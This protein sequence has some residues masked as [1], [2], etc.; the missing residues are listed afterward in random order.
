MPQRRLHLL[1]QN[2]LDQFPYSLSDGAS[3]PSRSEPSWLTSWPMLVFLTAYSSCARNL[4]LRDSGFFIQAFSGEYAFRF[5]TGIG[6][7]PPPAM[8][9]QSVLS[10]GIAETC[11]MTSEHTLHMQT[12]GTPALLRRSTKLPVPLD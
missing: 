11:K 3:K 9:S 4:L 12:S 5:P 10:G 2:D 1:L 7:E 8:F 6:T